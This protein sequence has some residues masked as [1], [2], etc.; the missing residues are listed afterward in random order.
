MERSSEM[1]TGP[2]ELEVDVPAARN[3]VV[4][5]VVVDGRSGVVSSRARVGENPVD[6]PLPVAGCGPFAWDV[7]VRMPCNREE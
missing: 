2:G 1:E 7:F 5:V 3:V 6:F 4:I